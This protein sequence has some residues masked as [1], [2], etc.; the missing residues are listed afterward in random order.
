VET[1]YHHHCHKVPAKEHQSLASEQ[2]WNVVGSP[3]CFVFVLFLFLLLLLL[4]LFLLLLLLLLFSPAMPDSTDSTVCFILGSDEKYMSS[5]TCMSQQFSTCGFPF[6]FLARE[7]RHIDCFSRAVV[8]LF[9]SP[10][11][12]SLVS[13][14]RWSGLQFVSLCWCFRILWRQCTMTVT[15]PPSSEIRTLTTSR[16]NVS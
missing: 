2:H 12:R 9:Y 6:L 5:M 3:G 1:G 7:G 14:I 13:N 8:H 11:A 15:T 4:V 16:R 10:L